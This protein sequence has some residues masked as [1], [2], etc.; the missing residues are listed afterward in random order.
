M[1]DF[2]RGD[3]PAY[4]AIIL[5]LVI[6]S[7]FVPALFIHTQGTEHETLEIQEGDTIQLKAP[8]EATLVSV[9]NAQLNVTVVDTETGDF[10]SAM[11]NEGQSAYLSLRGNTVTVTYTE[12]I[13]NNAAIVSFD[14]PVFY[15]W[16]TATRSFVRAIGLIILGLFVA[17][18]YVV[19]FERGDLD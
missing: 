1:P 9:N 15:E 7:G 14:Y 10:G 3:W 16:D 18:I 11:L 17:L 4:L 8:L 5:L 2:N 13:G 19:I 6:F 12:D